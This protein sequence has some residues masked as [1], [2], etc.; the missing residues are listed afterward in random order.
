MVTHPNFEF[1]LVYVRKGIRLKVLSKEKWFFG[2]LTMYK[3]K[4]WDWFDS[5]PDEH[6]YM[7]EAH[8]NRFLKDCI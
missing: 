3:Y 7:T 8:L 4:S 5:E 1:N 6:G 2:L